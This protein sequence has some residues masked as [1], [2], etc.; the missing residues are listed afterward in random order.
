MPKRK[1]IGIAGN[2]LVDTVKSID[3]YP[4]IGMLASILSQS[5][6]VGGCVPNTAINLAKLDSSVPI[7]AAGLVGNDDNGKYVISRLEDFGI[8]TRAVNITDNAP[9]SYSDVMSVS[10]GERTFFH[11]RGANAL[12]SGSDIDVASLDCEILHIGYA[13]LLDGFDK[14]DDEY[15]TVMARVLCN[16][17]KAG[18]K[19]SIDAVSSKNDNYGKIMKASYKYCDYAILN[20][21]ECCAAWGL[22][23]TFENGDPHISNIKA[24]MQKSISC[25]I[26][27]KMIVHSK[28]ASFCL[29][30]NG[31][32]TVVP[33][34]K[35]PKSE[36]KGS[37]GA[38]DS[39]CAA[40]LYGI[41]LGF[42][43]EKL[44]SFASAAAA[45][46]LRAENATDGMLPA[47]EI[48]KICKEYERLEL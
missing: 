40:A 29:D 31:T 16:A 25:G 33:S 10:G 20:E 3:Y 5:R 4:E 19:T 13:M 1:G 43:D 8:D 21:L 26:R 14:F 38:G 2:I 30:K 18:I 15:G 28:K 35:I 6:G 22:D 46:N 9:T 27:E 23:A 47:E 44:L 7:Y 24:A 34:L 12:F 41:Y 37:V 11:A 17:Q 39:F 36:I 48:E 45:C 42:G 32:F